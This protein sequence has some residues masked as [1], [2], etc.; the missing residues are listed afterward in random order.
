MDSTALGVLVGGLRRIRE[1]EGELLVVLPRGAARR[2]F[3]I[4]T[5]DRV[6]PI[7]ASRHEAIDALA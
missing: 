2:V 3:E 4:T 1:V 5:L 6:L 7:A